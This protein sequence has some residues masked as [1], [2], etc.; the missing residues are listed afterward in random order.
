MV[1]WRAVNEKSA[2][3]PRI[4]L[5]A[6]GGT[7]QM[8]GG[9]RLDLSTYSD[10]PAWM[11]SKE[12]MDR[13]PEVREVAQVKRVPFRRLRAQSLGAAGWHR[14]AATVER[15][16]ND[17]SVD[18][19]VISH[20]T[21]ALE[22]SAYMLSLVS[23][24]EKPI[25]MTGAMRPASALSADGDLNLLR[26]FQVAASRDSRDLGVLVVLNDTILAARDATK[27]TTFR[28]QS[29]AGADVG[30]I[31]FADSDGRIVYYHHPL[32]LHASHGPFAVASLRQAPRVDLLTSHVMADGILIDAAVAAG[33]QGIVIAAFGAGHITVAEQRA[34]R[35]AQR[36]GV[37]V[38]IATRV[39][40][41]RVAAR[42]PNNGAVL[43]DNLR[44]WK[45]RVLL[46]LALTIS[47]EPTEVQ[48]I[49]D[50]H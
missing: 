42:N 15:L 25:V 41:G 19:V 43:A 34:L 48:V 35:R 2:G 6:A 18:G 32:R 26:S 38:C 9:D 21:N 28:L 3:K 45:A 40:G 47:R 22:E 24:T 20:G 30:P 33:A 23:R 37:V 44:P 5:I 7:I 4:A 14:L 36:D 29:F 49:F 31:G 46:A 8:R 50:Q 13:I 39:P 10:H 11:S 27:T 1:L 16:V 17:A 12:L